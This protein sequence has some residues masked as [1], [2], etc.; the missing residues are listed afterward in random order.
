M[1]RAR[2][3]RSRAEAA[4]DLGAPKRRPIHARRQRL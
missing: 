1:R 4:I 3:A 2:P